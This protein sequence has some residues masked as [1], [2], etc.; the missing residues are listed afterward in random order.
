MDDQ[1]VISAS[2]ELDL[3]SEPAFRACV[4]GVLAQRG[5][6]LVLDLDEVTF[7]DARGLAALVAARNRALATCGSLRVTRNSRSVVR[8]LE[9]V[10]LDRMLSPLNG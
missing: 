7:M 1:V 2:G 5:T 6:H 8:L 4:D 3:A 10:G 9:L